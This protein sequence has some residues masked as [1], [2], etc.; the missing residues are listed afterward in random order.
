MPPH[1]TG[2][3]HP[4]PFERLSAQDFER[5]CLWLVR[6][7]K[8]Y[9]NVEWLGAGGKDQ[10]RDLVA[11]RDGMRVAFQCKRVQHFGPKDARAELEKLMGLAE[12]ERPDEVIFIVSRNVTAETR[13]AARTAWVDEKSCRFWSGG[14]LDEKVK[15]HPEILREFFQ[16]PTTEDPPSLEV[17]Q[18]S[19]VPNYLDTDTRRV[20]EALENAYQQRAEI[21]SADGDA[22]PL[23]AKI[24]SLRR[25]LREGGQ[26]K[27]GDFLLDGRFQL[28]KRIGHGGFATV[29]KG[30]DREDRNIVAIKVLHSQYRNDSTRIERFFRGARKM[31]DMDHP[32]IVRVLRKKLQDSYFYFFVME[33]VH[34]KNLHQ[35][36]LDCDIEPIEALNLVLQ[37]GD[38]LHFAHQQGVIHRD[39]KPSNIILGRGKIPKLTDFDLVRAFDTTGGTRTG[40][41]GTFIYAAPESMEGAKDADA[42]SDIYGLGMVSIFALLQEELPP[43]IIR[44]TSHFTLRLACRADVKSLIARA[45]AWKRDLRPASVAEFCD[46]IRKAMSSETWC[47][48]RGDLLYGGR[49]KLA[50]TLSKSTYTTIW[51]ATDLHQKS[52]LAL[53]VLHREMKEDTRMQGYLEK[54]REIASLRSVALAGKFN[55]YTD[56]EC[57]FSTFERAKGMSLEQIVCE[58][59]AAFSLAA[60]K[61]N[62]ADAAQ[63]LGY[64]RSKNIMNRRLDPSHIKVTEDGRWMHNINYIVRLPRLEPLAT[65]GHA[66]AGT[67]LASSTIQR[68]ISSLART[69]IFTLGGIS[70]MSEEV[71]SLTIESLEAPREMKILLGRTAFVDGHKPFSSFSA[72]RRAAGDSYLSKSLESHTSSR[73]ILAPMPPLRLNHKRKE[74]YLK[75][76]YYGPGLAGKAA[77]IRYLYNWYKNKMPNRRPPR[78]HLTTQT[79][80][81]LFFFFLQLDL[82]EI[83]G[84]R[85]IVKL[86]SGPGQVFYDATRKLFLPGT[87]GVIFVADSQGGENG[88]QHRI[89][90]EPGD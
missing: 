85:V 87:D 65:G 31:A 36:I 45:V 20:A 76:V 27:A 68:D 39:I 13:T 84:Y 42:R 86:I 53:S 28:L 78:L 64:L 67:G 75:I 83:C 37:I 72:L 15:Q 50:A 48:S 60:I 70:H 34:G 14:E 19:L 59:R 77:N 61:K 57:S 88:I 63:L 82:G 17:R 58:S 55:S 8:G 52:S 10:G 18:R 32:N 24:L 56:G 3:N 16:L 49:F 62:I 71:T 73:P 26:I 46:S 11:W 1:T 51:K 35:A 23:Q 29:W 89:H 9:E 44:D 7:E 38:A 41:L 6:R 74:L 80:R 66:Q 4:L 30:Y 12:N 5:L 43:A 90:E 54:L 79:D 47:F 25:Q 21:I 81:T 33:Y 2:S 40:M 69:A 22:E